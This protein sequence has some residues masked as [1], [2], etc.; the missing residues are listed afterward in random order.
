MPQMGGKGAKRG[1]LGNVG[2]EVVS[3]QLGHLKSEG[4][5]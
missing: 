4:S 2:S 1:A 5:G 3:F